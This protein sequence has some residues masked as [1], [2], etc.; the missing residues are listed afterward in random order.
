MIIQNKIILTLMDQ[1]IYTRKDY[2]WDAY[3]QVSIQELST[4]FGM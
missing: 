1:I 3:F 2:L 4:E